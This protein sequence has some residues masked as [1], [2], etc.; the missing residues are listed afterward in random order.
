MYMQ[1]IA[2]P[3]TS[4]IIWNL[5]IGRS[6]HYFVGKPESLRLF[7]ERSC[8]NIRLEDSTLSEYN[9]CNLTIYSSNSLTMK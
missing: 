8:E 1:A 3:I 6:A 7:T 5:Y 9:L 4:I 2:I